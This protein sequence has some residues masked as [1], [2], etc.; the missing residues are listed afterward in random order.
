MCEIENS[1]KSRIG[2]NPYKSLSKNPRFL[3]LYCL[4]MLLAALWSAHLAKGFPLPRGHAPTGVEGINWIGVVPAIVLLFG[5]AIVLRYS[6][7]IDDGLAFLRWRSFF[8]F[9]I[10]AGV[11]LSVIRG[12]SEQ[13]ALF[14]ALNG[15]YFALVYEIYSHPLLP[16]NAG[17]E[18]LKIHQTNWWHFTQVFLTISIAILVGISLSFFLGK[19]NAIMTILGIIVI[20]A[21]GIFCVLLYIGWKDRLI[22]LEA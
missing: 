21:V 16:Q 5:F 20:P 10:Y 8:V 3:A 2:I 1:S 6:P 13:F 15:G 11:T 19:F 14:T 4:A 12:F 9:I 17:Q 18:R 7:S 22:E